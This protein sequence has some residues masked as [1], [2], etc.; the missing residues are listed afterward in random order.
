M[1]QLTIWDILDPPK[2]S[3]DDAKW[4]SLW[5]KCRRECW[6]KKLETIQIRIVF[7]TPTG[8]RKAE[9]MTTS[10][11]YLQRDIREWR[12]DNKDKYFIYLEEI[13]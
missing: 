1:K 2:M 8:M 12:E 11:E 9:Q 10:R 7:Q 4:H 13:R 3:K 6:G 5:K